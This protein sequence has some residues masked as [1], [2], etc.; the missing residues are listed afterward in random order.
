MKQKLL[1]QN[2]GSKMYACAIG[3][4][5]GKI[6]FSLQGIDE[7]L[8]RRSPTRIQNP[9]YLKQKHNTEVGS[10]THVDK[11]MSPEW[12]GN[13]AVYRATKLATTQR[14]QSLWPTLW[15]V[16]LPG[17]KSPVC[18]LFGSVDLG[19]HK[20][21]T[22]L[23]DLRHNARG[24]PRATIIEGSRILHRCKGN[25]RAHLTCDS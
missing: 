2:T 4:L 9:E 7:I 10:K 3:T 20:Q 15:L 25:P 18:G 22:F 23:I 14:I 24:S 11:E 8:P 5:V 16:D 21:L 13:E 19:F 6:L 12:E 1:I 17:S